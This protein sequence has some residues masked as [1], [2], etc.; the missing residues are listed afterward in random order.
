VPAAAAANVANLATGMAIAATLSRLLCA[1]AAATAV[2]A[3]VSPSRW[4]P[5]VSLGRPGNLTCDKHTGQCCHHGCKMTCVALAGSPTRLA[6]RARARSFSLRAD[7]RARRR[8]CAA[9]GRAV[10]MGVT[11][12]A[13][14][15]WR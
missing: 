9:T 5:G 2:R 8:V 11:A 7:P 4:P 13:V 1:F 6:P 3:A 15:S 14:G 12:A 10:I